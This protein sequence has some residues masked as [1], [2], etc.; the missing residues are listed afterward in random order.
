MTEKDR[1]DI[2]AL[3]S[4]FDLDQESYR[5]FPRREPPPAR[6]AATFE[7]P[8]PEIAEEKGGESRTTRA[9]LRSLWRHLVPKKDVER[10]RDFQKLLAKSI[11]AYGAAGGVGSTTVIAT[12]AR[13]LAKQRQ[14]CAIVD[15]R[16]RSMAPFY[17]GGHPVSHGHKSVA[18]W[19]SASES[20]IRIISRDVFHSDLPTDGSDEHLWYERHIN[21]IQGSLDHLLLDVSDRKSARVEPYLSTGV[22]LL[23]AIPDVSSI[24]GAMALKRQFA[25]DAP[26]VTTICVLNKFDASLSLHADIREWFATNFRTVTLSRSDLVGDALAEGLTVIDWA[27]ESTVAAE[28]GHLLEVIRLS[29]HQRSMVEQPQGIQ[30]CQ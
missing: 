1:D 25:E 8:A 28:F 7:L 10:E 18:G 9:A 29:F 27:P 22:A 5:V 3:C 16:E 26:N 12:L 6:E 15:G 14:D 17:F 11:F 13:L 23:V 21:Q 24:T 30:V 2:F 4:R 20:I 19:R